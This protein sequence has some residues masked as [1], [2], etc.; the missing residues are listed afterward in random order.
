VRNQTVQGQD[1]EPGREK[2]IAKIG[3]LTSASA[4]RE[5]KENLKHVEY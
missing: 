4:Q 1:A 5:Q 2:A 3:H